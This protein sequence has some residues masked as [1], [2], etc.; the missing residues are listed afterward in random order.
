MTSI[1]QL[2]VIDKTSFSLPISSKGIEVGV[3]NFQNF[4]VEE[5]PSLSDYLKSGWFINMSCAIDYTASNGDIHLA[6]SLHR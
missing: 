4:R 5:K 6:D 3:L 1:T 2:L